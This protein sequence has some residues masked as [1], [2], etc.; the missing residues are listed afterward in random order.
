MADPIL[1]AGYRTGRDLVAAGVDRLQLTTSDVIEMSLEAGLDLTTPAE[2][3][4]FVTG[5]R[6]AYEGEPHP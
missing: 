5:I 3:S 6:N 4:S 2:T 1:V